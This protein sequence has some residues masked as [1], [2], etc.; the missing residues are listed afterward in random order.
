[1]S[2]G[3]VDYLPFASS[4]GLA[5]HKDTFGALGGFDSS[6]VNGE[7]IDLCWRA[8]LDGRKIV[9][10][11]DAVLHYRLRNDAAEVARQMEGYGYWTVPLVEK[12]RE[13]GMPRVPVREGLKAW[14]KLLVRLPASLRTAEGRAQWW[15]DFAYRWGLLKGSIEHRTLVL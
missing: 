7:D 13:H 12:Y 14:A 8:Q 2:F 11:G 3:Y 6:L 1:M 4:S 10:A 9:F 15:V 5:M